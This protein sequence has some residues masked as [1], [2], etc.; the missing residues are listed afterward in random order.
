ME[1]ALFLGWRL[2]NTLIFLKFVAYKMIGIKALKA[3]IA[4]IVPK[5]LPIMGDFNV[6]GA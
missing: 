1:N 6:F 5:K 3:R 4:R 2:K